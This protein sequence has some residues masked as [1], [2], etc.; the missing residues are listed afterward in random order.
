MLLPLLLNN[1][2]ETGGAATWEEA[3]RIGGLAVSADGAIGAIFLDDVTAVPSSAFFLGG[4]A[5][6]SDGKRYI[7]LWPAND[8]V[9]YRGP[10][11]CRSDGA[12]IIVT[13]GTIADRPAGIAQTFR[14]EVLATTSTPDYIKDAIGLLTSGYMC[15]EEVS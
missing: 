13:S 5:H 3:V 15:M 9:H 1:L 14:G 2:L 8:A 10:I 12:M 11:A 6:S 7:C 4:I